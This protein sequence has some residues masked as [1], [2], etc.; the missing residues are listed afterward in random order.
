M[1]K[2]VLIK[3]SRV[4]EEDHKREGSPVPREVK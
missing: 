2:E 4:R 3:Q 1:E